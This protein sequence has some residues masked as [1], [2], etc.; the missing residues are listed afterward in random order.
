MYTGLMKFGPITGEVAL[1]APRVWEVK[2]W[3]TGELSI[4]SALLEQW[5][6][7]PPYMVHAVPYGQLAVVGSIEAM[8][9]RVEGYDRKDTSRGGSPARILGERSPHLVLPSETRQNLPQHN[10]NLLTFINLGGTAVIA[11]SSLFAERLGVQAKYDRVTRQIHDE[12]AADALRKTITASQRDVL[13][14]RILPDV[15]VVR[16]LP[17]AFPPNQMGEHQAF[18]TSA[19]R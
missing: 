12:L 9:E 4:N 19:L 15:V 1:Q 17:E 7:E 3:K 13:S 10:G 18:V 2:A 16:M 5:E 14:A 6:V 11:P 8:S